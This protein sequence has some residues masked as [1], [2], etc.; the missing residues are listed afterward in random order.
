MYLLTN[1]IT[2]EQ[3]VG[4]T[5]KTVARRWYAHCISAQSP[6]FPIAVSIATYG[7]DNFAIQELFAA[8]DKQSLNWAEQLFIADLQPTLNRTRGGAG[9]P[10]RL[11]PEECANRSDA[12]KRRWA[13][14]EWKAKT[15]A[16]LKNAVR[17]AVPYEVLRAHGKQICAKRWAGHVKKARVANGTEERTAQRVAATTQTWQNPGVRER[18]IAA[19]QQANAR[20]EV[21]ERKRLAS[22]GRRMPKDAVEKAARAKWKPVF[23]P[24]LQVSFL[25]QKHAAEFFGVLRT[26]INNA[27]TRKGRV[28]RKFTLEMVA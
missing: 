12:A 22:I 1:Q 28:Q 21:K 9:T 19:I 6:K 24:E 7:K 13:N 4:Q 27:V 5:I 25:S 10:R 16:S 14:P 18:R 8:L 23:C 17:K 3:Y 26:S 11:T 2:G 20:P 15:V